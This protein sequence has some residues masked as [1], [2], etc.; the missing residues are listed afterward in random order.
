[1]PVVHVNGSKLNFPD[2]TPVEEIQAAVRKFTQSA[3]SDEGRRMV[4]GANPLEKTMVGL[5]SMV[6]E[7]VLGLKQAYQQARGQ[8]TTDTEQTIARLRGGREAAGGWG[9]AGELGGWAL[10]GIGGGLTKLASRAL[11]KVL[12]AA[13][14]GA[15]EQAAYNASKGTLEGDPSR[16]ENAAS[17][18]LW[19]A[20]GAVGGQLLPRALGAAGR[21]FAKVAPEAADVIQ[22]F[23]NAGMKAPLTVGQTLGGGWKALEERLTAYPGTGLVSAREKALKDWNTARMTGEARRALSP[24]VVGG[25]AHPELRPSEFPA[26][27]G[28]MQNIRA[29]V[30]E[31]YDALFEG[32]EARPVTMPEKGGFENALQAT[33]NLTGESKAVAE[34]EIQRLMA[35]LQHGLPANQIKT[36]DAELNSMISKAYSDAKYGL[37]DALTLLKHDFRELYTRGW[38]PYSKQVLQAA[39]DFYGATRPMVEASATQ[40][41]L[42]REGVF[43]P[44][45]ELSRIRAGSKPSMLSAGEA[46]GQLAA[47]QANKVLGSRLPEVGP[48]TAEKILGNTVLGGAATLLT[49]AASPAAAVMMGLPMA[50]GRTMASPHVARMA[51]GQAMWQTPQIKALAEKIAQQYGVSAEVAAAWLAQQM[52]EQNAP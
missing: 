26:G 51:T 50:A 19:G 15:A 4:E 43:T 11:P 10:G 33:Q 5:G 32:P 45:Q 36:W 46:R 31:L 49:G 9:T 34:G 7:P 14:T 35:D 16:A 39:D 1:M 22:Q 47:E 21:G 37:G 52:G 17:G 20:G 30:S 28:G 29:K 2:G 12:A 3:A 8:D 42:T 25:A 38:T 13:G 24:I 18:A 23:A 6:A 27:H 41:A 40:G 44:A 48:G